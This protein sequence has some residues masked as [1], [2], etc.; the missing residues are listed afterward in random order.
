MK[1]WSD[2]VFVVNGSFLCTTQTKIMII[3]IFVIQSSKRMFRKISF[4]E[5]WKWVLVGPWHYLA[6]LWLCQN[7][8]A[9]SP[10]A[11][12]PELKKIQNFGTNVRNPYVIKFMLFIQIKSNLYKWTL[13]ERGEKWKFESIFHCIFTVP[14]FR[15][16]YVFRE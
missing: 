3:F 10:K 14:E 9:K 2:S 7:R 1:F 4:F 11:Q 12:F 15:I 5:Y 13:I 6:I 16:L 8:L